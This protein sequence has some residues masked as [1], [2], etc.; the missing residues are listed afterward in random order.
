MSRRANIEDIRTENMRQ[1]RVKYD[2]VTAVLT[3]SYV[4][5]GQA[6]V[7]HFLEAQGAD[8]DVYLPALDP[9]GGQFFIIINIGASNALNVRNAGGTL[10]E[11]VPAQS[12]FVTFISN[13]TAWYASTVQATSGGSGNFDA[14][15][16]NVA[17]FGPPFMGQGFTDDVFA[18][19]AAI[20]YAYNNGRSVVMIPDGFYCT[21]SRPIW[22]APPGSY[23]S[24]DPQTGGS[25]TNFQHTMALIGSQVL[26]NTQAKGVTIEAYNVDIN[27]DI[28]YNSPYADYPIVIVGPGQGMYVAGLNVR[29]GGGSLFTTTFRSTNIGIAVSGGPGGASRTMVEKCVVMNCRKGFVTGWNEDSLADSNTFRKCTTIST[30]VGFHFKQTQNYINSLIDCNTHSTIGVLSDVGKAVNIWGGSFSYAGAVAV[31]FAISGTTTFSNTVGGAGGYDGTFT[32]TITY[33]GELFGFAENGFTDDPTT[34]IYNAFAIETVHFGI[35]PCEFVSYNAA[36]NAVTLKLQA[37][38][39]YS[40][41]GFN[42]TED[43]VANTDLQA[44]V[45]ACTTLHAAQR[46]TPF[47]GTGI[48]AY[49]PHLES[50]GSVFCLVDVISGFQGDVQCTIENPY[51]NFSPTVDLSS[52]PRKIQSVWP[53]VA[54]ING[55]VRITGGQL[56]GGKQVLPWLITI[57]NGEA[58]FESLGIYSPN[59]QVPTIGNPFFNQVTYTTWARGSGFWPRTPFIPTKNVG[60]SSN[61]GLGIGWVQQNRGMYPALGNMPAPGATLEITSAFYDVVTASPITAAMGEYPIIVGGTLYRVSSYN[62]A[63]GSGGEVLTM[64]DHEMFSYGQDFT[65]N[66]SY[67]GQS[68]CLYVDD[69]GWF[70]PG[71]K[72]GIDNGGGVAWYIV[73]GVYTQDTG[74]DPRAGYVTVLASPGAGRLAGTKTVV[75]TGS[76]IYQEPYNWTQL[77]GGKAGIEISIVGDSG[78]VISTGIKVHALEVPFDCTLVGVSMFGDQTGSI[79]VDIWKDTYANYPPDNA[80]SITSATPPTISSGVKMKDTTLAGWTTVFAE[81]EILRINVDSVSNFTNLTIV[82]EVNKR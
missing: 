80:D 24:V 20:D 76:T 27:D 33:A 21:T 1:T 75:Y 67:K 31:D 45:Q 70:F 49:G 38:W 50:P 47:K 73:R 71:L 82:L 69:V 60:W 77:G 65:M 29:C 74:G 56:S 23:A 18:I 46:V 79:V 34:P 59:I 39:V 14:F 9:L 5:A 63:V 16:V 52:G 37:D 81:G 66:W 4:I 62:A 32:T 68:P 30:H 51:F 26:G 72:F 43:L 40:N 57:I 42:L 58:Q 15:V 25:F 61:D 55:G 2:T 17:D 41:Y 3:G 10:I 11:T 78:G 22:I 8:R 48:H 19:Q 64:S 53:M 44:E 7:M 12:D 13:P 54:A 35:I 6:P 36:T 28:D